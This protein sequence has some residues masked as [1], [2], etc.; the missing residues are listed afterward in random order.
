MTSSSRAVGLWATAAA[1][2]VLLSGSWAGAAGPNAAGCFDPADYGAA[3]SP[4]DARPGAQ[5][6]LDAAA[7]AG[8]GR[9]CFGAA[10]W[11]LSRAPAGS[12][13]RFAALSTHGAHI[14]ITGAGPGTVLEIAGDQGAGTLWVIALD[15]GAHDVTLRDLTIDTSAAVNTDEQTHAIEVGSGLGTGPVE[16][17]RIERVR[18][19]HPAASDGSR[20]GDCLRLVGAGADTPVRRVTVIGSTFT[21]CARSGIAIQRNVFDLVIEGNQFTQA[22]DQDIDSEP[23][24]S[25]LDGS[26]AIV[27]NV[28]NDDVALGQGDFSVTIGGISEPMARVTLANNVFQ[29]RG[30]GF[31]RVA[32]TTVTGNTFDATMKSGLGVI[33]IENVAARVVIQGNALRRRGAMGAPIRVIHH[34]GGAASQL[35]IANNVL[36]NDTPG[37]GVDME[38]AQDVTVSGNDMS[39][40]VPAPSGS[41]VRLRSVIRPADGVMISGN[42][43]AGSLFAGIFL[44]AS[45][46]PFGAV[47]IVGN[48]MRG[49][50]V[51][52]RCE[53][54]IAG[55]FTQPI[56]HVANRWEGP[57]QCPATSLVTSV[58]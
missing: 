40:T 11:R 20:K 13:D 29:G 53:Q 1:L 46:Q 55:N 6:A 8:G 14:E 3:P 32:D 24:G 17:V 10:R 18:F 19:V 58:P 15:P 12:Y 28:F 41:G 9:V 42:R 31:Y 21:S 36:T 39:W 49:S 33:D 4:A 34:S 35:V 23:T 16:D 43:I 5:A 37:G 47:S 45:P 7:A 2:A 56:I 50:P 44:G 30:V 48:M 54:S 57:P 25:G 26:I 27:G 52:L 22:G 38:S 51:G